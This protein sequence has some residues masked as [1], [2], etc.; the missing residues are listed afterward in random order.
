MSAY[1]VGSFEQNA[2]SLFVRPVETGYCH[3]KPLPVPDTTVASSSVA[4]FDKAVMF[5]V[6]DD[7]DALDALLR[8]QEVRMSSSFI[9]FQA[10]KSYLGRFQGY[11]I[12]V[13]I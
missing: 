11:V 7:P 9:L 2:V 5:I 3:M 6:E 4:V 12:H 1:R 13:V 8:S 10:P